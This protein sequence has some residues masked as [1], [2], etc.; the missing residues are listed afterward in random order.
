MEK[1]GCNKEIFV[2][3][4]GINCLKFEKE[5]KI[6]NQ[7][8][9]VGRL[10]FYK[11]VDVLI[12]AFKKVL[13]KIPDA[14]LVIIGDGPLRSKLEDKEKEAKI[15][16]QIIFKGYVSENEKIKLIQQSD[17][18]LNPSF[19]EGFGLTVLE[20]FACEKPVIVSDVPPLPDLIS[21]TKDGFIVNAFDSSEWAKKIIQVMS[22][23]AQSV[24]MG[25]NGRS[26]LET[27]FS[28]NN[29]VDK[30]IEMYNTVISNF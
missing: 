26:K 16:N 17:V 5:P 23:P 27:E 28:L 7:A 25:K 2:I 14:R 10:I 13:Q 3:S 11:N 6:S 12:D 9:F 19:I 4:N 15:S 29:K 18:L 22:N 30:I 24:I 1:I 8:I 20:G 21:D